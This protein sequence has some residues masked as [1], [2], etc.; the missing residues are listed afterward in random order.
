[1]LPKKYSSEIYHYGV[2]GMKWGVRRTPEQLRRRVGKVERKTDNL[3]AYKRAL[4]SDAETYSTKANQ[5]RLRNSKY[6]SRLT[7]ASATKAKYDLKIEAQENKRRPSQRKLEKYQTKSAEAQRQILKAQKKLK[8]NNWEIKA[9]ETREA[10][11]KAQAKIEKNE[12]LMSTLNK[13]ISALDA[14]TIQ[15]GKYF[16]RYE[17]D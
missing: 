17:E 6:Q 16:M 13:T 7:K 3:K 5:M 8:Y 2:L 15:Q 1:M 4:D 11:R 12:K 14:G 9:I 10:A